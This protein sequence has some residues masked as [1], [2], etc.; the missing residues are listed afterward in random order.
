MNL[1]S[2]VNSPRIKILRPQ[3]RFRNWSYISPIVITNQACWGRNLNSLNSPTTLR[4]RSSSNCSLINRLHPF[5]EIS[6]S[7][8]F[9]RKQVYIKINYFSYH[10]QMHQAIHST[11]YPQY[12][13][14]TF[15]S[16]KLS[17]KF[18]RVRFIVTTEW[19]CRVAQILFRVGRWDTP[20][21]LNPISK[22]LAIFAR[23]WVTESYK[24]WSNGCYYWRGS[25]PWI[26]N[27]LIIMWM[28]RQYSPSCP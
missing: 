14:E 13:V 4:R 24:I 27:S 20:K 17:N 11:L 16:T 25:Q 18:H 26:Y 5:L 12:G 1:R 28:R 8:K 15:S 10:P 7:S 19:N 23:W 3:L 22:Y 9:F 2:L 21:I 6:R